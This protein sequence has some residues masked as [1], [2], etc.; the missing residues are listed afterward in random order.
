[1]DFSKWNEYTK[2]E[3]RSFMVAIGAVTEARI[4]PP[5]KYVWVHH[6]ATLSAADLDVLKAWAFAEPKLI[7]GREP[8]TASA[9]VGAGYCNGVLT[10][11]H[12]PDVRRYIRP[13]GYRLAVKAVHAIPNGFDVERVHARDPRQQ[14]TGD[15]V[16]A[17]GREAAADDPG[18]GM[19]LQLRHA[20]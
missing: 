4:M 18:V 17:A 3:R 19:D 1:M 8:I 5:A 14:L 15:D 12:H 10:V 2:T 20:R 9:Q 7:P 11:Q 16:V 6:Q 13:L